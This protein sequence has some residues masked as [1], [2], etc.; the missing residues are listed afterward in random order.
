MEC[1]WSAKVCTVEQWKW[2]QSDSEVEESVAATHS[3]EQ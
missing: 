3:S 1:D 2:R